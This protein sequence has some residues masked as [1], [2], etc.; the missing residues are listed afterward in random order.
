MLQS[1][2]FLYRIETQTADGETDFL[3][4]YQLASRISFLVWGSPP[5]AK[6]MD[7]ASDGELGDPAV[8]AKHVQRMLRDPRAV[9]RSRDFVSQWLNLDH[10]N[11]LQPDRERFPKWDA[12]LADQMQEETLRFFEHIVWNQRRPLAD[13]LDAQVTFCSS[14]LAEHYRM[15]TPESSDTGDSQEGDFKRYD[16]SQIAE[17][18]GLLTQGSLLTIGGDDASMVTRGLFVLHELLRGVV[19]DPPPCVDTSPQ[20]TRAGV[21]ARTI[22]EA[23]IKNESC[24]GCHVRFEPLAF[25]LERFD[26]LGTYHERDEHDNPLRGDG[27]LLI[28]GE[29]EAVSFENAGEL[30]RLLAKSDRVQETLVWKL[31]QFSLGRPPTANEAP[32]IRDIHLRSK[33]KGGTYQAILSE[34]ILSPLVMP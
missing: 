24:G 18:G 6:L 33:E 31:A 15:S 12:S 26:G 21:S 11:S 14:E 7:A 4:D 22:S 34:I 10:L 23:R 17:R 5:D 2:R 30:M 9:A 29:P 8:V 20:P 19:N 25:G 13:L 3:D 32:T 16:L 27:N 28:P 1:P